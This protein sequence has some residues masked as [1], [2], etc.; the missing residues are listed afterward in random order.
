ML[1]TTQK[2][3]EILGVSVSTVYRMIEQGM[4]NP[5]KT[6]GGQRRFD[7]EQLIS[8]K[9]NSKFITAPQNP[10]LFC[11]FSAHRQRYHLFLGFA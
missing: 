7:T 2:A 8:F 6:P 1:V 4:L 11:K 3:A 5:T 9:E 10:S